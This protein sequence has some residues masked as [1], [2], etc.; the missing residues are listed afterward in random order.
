[1]SKIKIF[2]LLCLCILSGLRSESSGQIP[3]YILKG[4][5]VDVVTNQPVHKVTITIP[6]LAKEIQSKKGTFVV[7]LPEKPAILT[8]YAENHKILVTTLSV[9]SDT[10]IIFYLT[11]EIQN[12]SLEEVTVS[13]KFNPKDKYHNRG[14]EAINLAIVPLMPSLGGEP[15]VL[16]S[17][18]LYPGIQAVSEGSPGISVRGGENSENL[19]LL[20]NAPIYSISSLF[21]LLS[22]F[23]PDILD[24]FV[25][26]K[27]YLP[28]QYGG[29][30]SSVV[31]TRLLSAS[32]DSMIFKINLGTLSSSLLA[33]SRNKE[34]RLSWMLEARRSYLDMFIKAYNRIADESTIYPVYYNIAGKIAFE[35]KNHSLSLTMYADNDKFTRIEED[36][37]LL[38]TYRI[39]KQNKLFSFNDEWHSAN[40]RIQNNL[41]ISYSR[42]SYGMNYKEMETDSLFSYMAVGSGLN[43]FRVKEM[44]TYTVDKCLL[45][46]GLE[47]VN[48]SVYPLKVFTDPGNEVLEKEGYSVVN[49]LSVFMQYERKLLKDKASFI[50]GTR[51][52]YLPGISTKVYFTPGF[53]LSYHPKSSQVVSLF[54]NKSIQPLFGFSNNGIGFPFEFWLPVNKGREPETCISFGGSYSNDFALGDS[55]FMFNTSV[56]QKYINGYSLFTGTIKTG[57]IQQNLA[58]LSSQIRIGTGRSAGIEFSIEKKNGRLTGLAAYTYSRSLIKIAGIN[59]G[60]EFSSGSDRPH[61]FNL[62]LSYRISKHWSVSAQWYLKSG[63]PVSIPLILYRSPGFGYMNGD[64]GL[65]NYFMYS[66]ENINKYRLPVYHRLDIA[67]A[68]NFKVLKTFPAALNFGVYNVYNRKNPYFC[69]LTTEETLN[70]FHQIISSVIVLRAVSMFPA[71]PFASFSMKFL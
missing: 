34:S 64:I 4:N 58:T 2:S 68:Y 3:V 32:R 33:A 26:Y 71:I 37:E 11:P 20:D 24:R 7:A 69:Y 53:E 9:S 55:Y 36:G 23:S 62:S 42:F 6:E 30:I 14:I 66:V 18:T 1:M 28:V 29:R 54:F 13:E 40:D 49:S 19:F 25:I 22:P 31:D 59:N 46:G 70:E 35:Q 56:Y 50:G 27:S 12:Y 57:D 43:D 38:K 67:F 47:Y 48:Y 10:T 17:L 65:K 51:I 63:K 39:S 41:N 52:S 16:K 8:F 60:E 44:L 5:V 15:D 45:S 61:D 21:G